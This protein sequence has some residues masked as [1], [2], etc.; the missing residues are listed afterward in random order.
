MEKIKEALQRA[1]EERTLGPSGG[2]KR[3]HRK[4][5][6]DEQVEKGITYSQTQIEEI[7]EEVMLKNH[8][9][10]DSQTKDVITAY[11]ILRTQVLQRLSSQGWNALAVTSPAPAAGKTV[12]AINLAISL[13]RE[14]QHTVLLVD[15]DL[16]NPN[17]A[18]KF[19]LNN[20]FGI[21]DYLTSD[22]PL[23][24]M[25]VNPG[26]E[27]L[28]LLPGTKPVEN[29]SELLSSPKMVR[30]VDELKSRYPSRFVIFD[31]PPLL[32]T[33]DALAFA[34]YVDSTLL[35]LHEGVTTNTEVKRSM[36]MLGNISVL[37][38]VLNGSSEKQ[39]TYY[40]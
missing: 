23:V 19:N 34:P 10:C 22:K 26:I 32:T 9:I 3:A 12:T 18:K 25:L 4:N 13:A 37:G 14:V 15:L 33:D 36:E 7:N 24:E 2:V 21:L 20:E 11:N 16:R 38:T 29:S 17:V 1:K 28:V 40:Y 35:V 39:N 30:L 6:D 8:L 27:R 5:K 31:L